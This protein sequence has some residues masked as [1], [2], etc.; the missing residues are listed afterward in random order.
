MIKSTAPDTPQ[1]EAVIRRV[2]VL[3]DFKWTPIRDVPSFLKNIGNTTLPQGVEVT[4]FPYSSTEP[5]DCFICEN[6]SIETFVSA[7]NNPYSRLYQPGRA[8]LNCSNYGIVCNGLVRYALGIPYRVPTKR[9]AQIDGMEMIKDREKYTVYDLELCDVL[10]VFGFGRNHVAMITDILRDGNEIVEI[11]VSEA[12]RP[13]CV[14]R[15]FS[16]E[17]FYEKYKLFS[18]W[19]YK[20]LDRVP[21]YDEKTD[22]IIKNIPTPVVTVDRGNKSN[23]LLGEEIII[24]LFSNINGNIE[25]IRNG[26]LLESI[27]VSGNAV[28]LKKLPVGYYEIKFNEFSCEFAVNC[29]TI[30]HTVQGNFLTVNATSNDENSEIV[31]MDFRVEGDGASSLCKFEVLTEEEKK[32]G[33]FTR[34]IDSEAKKFKVFFKNKY[35][36]WTHKMEEI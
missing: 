17:E 29:A 7:I 28:I 23:Y 33:I 21:L 4:G 24:S 31:Y 11:E 35:G 8:T 34:P 36:V 18:L 2:R 32:S 1:K 20:Y 16:V 13:S 14:K 19:R 9:W 27:A 25:I 5:I 6:V 26:A 12:I 30:T 15:R 3:T 10:H 22:E